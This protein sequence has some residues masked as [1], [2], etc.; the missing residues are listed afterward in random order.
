MVKSLQKDSNP[1]MLGTHKRDSPESAFN[2][3]SKEPKHDTQKVYH[4][5]SNRQTHH[6]KEQLGTWRRGKTIV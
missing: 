4:F 3:S 6:I 2:K 5:T 1:K